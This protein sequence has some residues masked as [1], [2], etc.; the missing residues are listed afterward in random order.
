M[1]ELPKNALKISNV[2]EITE[3]QR[4]KDKVKGEKKNPKKTIDAR[5]TKKRQKHPTSA[6]VEGVYAIA[7]AFF[8]G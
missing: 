4:E 3:V 1:R 5:I 6:E 8:F 7:P 2:G